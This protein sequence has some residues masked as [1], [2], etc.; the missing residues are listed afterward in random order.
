MKVTSAQFVKGIRG[1]D[2]VAVNGIPQVSFVGR[3]N[4]GKSSLIAAIVHDRSLVKISN[5]PGKTREIN[6]FLIN[7]N[8]YLVDLPGYGY[9]RVGPEEKE[10]L[11]KLIIWY[12]TDKTIRPRTVVLVVDSRV[13]ITKFDTQMI[14]I[15][16]DEGHPFVIVANKIDKLSRKELSEQVRD[17][18]AAAHGA[19]V[20][21]TSAEKGTGVKELIAALFV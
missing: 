1:T 16:T 20:F 6:F 3:S 15:L 12:L 11:Q 2:G 8:Q 14:E 10:K 9:A 5:T 19:E 21:L 4:V 7:Q 17:I 18:K 13:G